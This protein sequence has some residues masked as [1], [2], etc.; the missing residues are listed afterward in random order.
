MEASGVQGAWRRALDEFVGRLRGIYGERLRA[1][2]L[3]GSR[4]RGEGAEDSDIDTLVVLRPLDDFWREFDR[5]SPVAG[6]LSLKHGVVIC[7]RPT[8][9]EEFSNSGSPFFLNVRREGIGVG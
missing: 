7:T 8:S 6:E 1:V 5:V 9:E 4:A 2:V 3:Y